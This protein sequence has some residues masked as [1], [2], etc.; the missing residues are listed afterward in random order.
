[1]THEQAIERLD[2]YASGELP[3]IERVMV[4]R[5]L[6][7]CAECR[8]EVQEIRSLLA[9]AKALPAGIAPSR[10]LWGG[11]AERLEPRVPALEIAGEDTRVISLAERRRP[12][13]PPRWALQAAAA[14]VLVAGSSAVTAVL[15]R[16]HDQQ[17]G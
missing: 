7:G 4:Q 5:H 12:W 14:V 1:M 9:L 13:Q 2:D 16:Q 3:D 11:I 8:A 15:M 17:A 10:E 6:D